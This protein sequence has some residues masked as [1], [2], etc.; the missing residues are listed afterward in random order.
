MLRRHKF[1]RAISSLPLRRRRRQPAGAAIPRPLGETPDCG[2]PVGAAVSW[3][4]LVLR[5]GCERGHA[6]A[7]SEPTAELGRD[8]P[9]L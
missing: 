4:R 8:M 5:G 1:V 2:R 9:E 6:S 3:S 7:V